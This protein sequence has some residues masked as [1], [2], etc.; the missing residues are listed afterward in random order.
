MFSMLLVPPTRPKWKKNSLQSK[1]LLIPKQSVCSARQRQHGSTHKHWCKYLMTWWVRA[2]H[3]TISILTNRFYT[4]P[5]LNFCPS[6]DIVI[7]S[8]P[9]RYVCVC[10][11]K[12]SQIFI[13]D[14]SFVVFFMYIFAFHL[15]IHSTQCHIKYY[16]CCYFFSSRC[17]KTD[18]LRFVLSRP[19]VYMKQGVTR[20][21]HFIF[22]FAITD[23]HARTPGTHDLY[24]AIHFFLLSLSRSVSDFN[25]KWNTFFCHF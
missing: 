9:V 5:I 15:F 16:R 18:C 19:H 8:Q 17:H 1:T 14:L 20:S 6:C 11:R 7:L 3:K 12:W 2:A 24:R 25:R 23:V 10:A 22:P 13:N 21:L 4:M